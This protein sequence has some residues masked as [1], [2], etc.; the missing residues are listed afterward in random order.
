[1]N[2]SLLAIIKRIVAEQG[3]DVLANPQRLKPLV[4]DYAKDEPKEERRAFGRCIEQGFYQQIKAA[5]TT[6]ERRRIKAS[7]T[8]Q[9]QDTTGLS[10]ALCAGALDILDALAPLAAPMLPVSSPVP[11]AQ[12]HN[13]SGL[14]TRR[15]NTGKISIKTL[16]FAVAAGIGALAGEIV[17]EFFRIND[18]TAAG[19]WGNVLFVGVWAAFIGLGITIA[20]NVAQSIYLKRRP[21]LGILIKTAFIG[22][23]IGVAGGA[24]A[25]ILFAF[26]SNISTLVEI[27]SRIICWGILGWGLGFGASFFVPNYPA[28]RAMLAGLLGGTVGGAIFRATFILPGPLSRVIGVTILGIFIGLFISIIEEALRE[29]WLTVVWGPKETT[30]ISLGQKPVVFGA[31]READVFLPQRQG[32][33]EILPIHAVVSINGGRVMLEERTSGASRELH[34]GE[35]VDLG[36]VS[37]IANIRKGN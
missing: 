24:V 28:K 10:A 26:T 18:N 23:A 22:I 9:L 34:N 3:E 33:P 29:A 37:I 2:A 7:L 31:S 25:Q 35:A 17:S 14:E 5:N 4:G 8:R 12:T 16:I 6:A 20:L 36:R 13:V 21:P 1:M 32:Q 19:F 15:A 11:A 30:T 27:I